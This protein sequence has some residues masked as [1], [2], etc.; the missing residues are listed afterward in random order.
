MD[1]LRDAILLNNA[2][3]NFL[4]C[5]NMDDALHAFQCAVASVKVATTAAASWDSKEQQ[6]LTVA[7]SP[8]IRAVSPTSVHHHDSYVVSK[9]YEGLS[10]ATTA[11]PSSKERHA[12]VMLHGLQ[13]GISYIYNRPLFIPTDITIHDIEHLNS[14]I[15]TCSTYIV[16]NFALACHLLGT[17]SGTEDYLIRAARLYEL[18]LKVLGSADGTTSSH[19]HEMHSILECLAL[20]NLAQMHYEQCNYKLCQFYMDAMYDRFMTV[21]CMDSFLDANEMEEIMLNLVYLQ[22]PP[23]AKAA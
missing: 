8:P 16:F 7:A 5:D 3:V 6:P 1:P 11:A 15:L 22:S 13:N 17:K 14:V 9:Y 2:G 4:D 21:D 19:S 10:D 12:G 20:N 18:T 23:V